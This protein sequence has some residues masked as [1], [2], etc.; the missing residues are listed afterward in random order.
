MGLL[1]VPDVHEAFRALFADG[2]V[3]EE[4]FGGVE[5]F[6]AVED[7]DFLCFVVEL[8]LEVIVF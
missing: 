8:E 4:F 1:V 5:E 6:E 7:E 2:V 3:F